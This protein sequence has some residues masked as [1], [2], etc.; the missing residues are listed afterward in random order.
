MR[1]VIVDMGNL[2]SLGF[3]DG[4]TLQALLEIDEEELPVNLLLIL[5]RAAYNL[6]RNDLL[7]LQEVRLQEEVAGQDLGS[8][9]EEFFL[10]T[11]LPDL[12]DL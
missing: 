9:F 6:V 12:E 11:I 3:E 5:M 1:K 10:V 4:K 7:L 8:A 2:Y